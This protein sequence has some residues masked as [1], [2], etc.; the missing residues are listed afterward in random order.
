M[1]CKAV[2]NASKDPEQHC[3]KLITLTV[4]PG[5]WVFY[6]RTIL[7]KYMFYQLFRFHY[8]IL[9]QQS[10]IPDTTCHHISTLSVYNSRPQ[11][12]WGFGLSNSDQLTNAKPWY[13]PLTQVAPF[14]VRVSGNIFIASVSC[15]TEPLEIRYFTFP[16]PAQK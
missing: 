1:P 16:F 13:Y 8:E 10:I 5:L 4:V 11:R 6:L 9:L 12:R 2:G 3:S 14:Y 15:V 7:D